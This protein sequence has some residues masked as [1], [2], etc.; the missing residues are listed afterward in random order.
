MMDDGRV[1]VDWNMYTWMLN[2]RCALMGVDMN[3]D[4][5]GCET[6]IWL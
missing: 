1:G 2:F 5:C 4:A 3:M 6:G